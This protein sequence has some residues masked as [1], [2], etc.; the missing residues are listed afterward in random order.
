MEFATF[1]SFL[2]WRIHLLHVVVVI[3]LLDT[4]TRV[5]RVCYHHQTSTAIDPPAP[6]P[7]GLH[8]DW[9]IPFTALTEEW[10]RQVIA[11][12]SS[13]T[14]ASIKMCNKVL[15][16]SNIGHKWATLSMPHH[17]GICCAVYNYKM[18]YTAWRRIKL[19]FWSPAQD[20]PRGECGGFIVFSRKGSTK[21]MHTSKTSDDDK[22]PRR[23]CNMFPCSDSSAEKYGVGGRQRRRETCKE[24]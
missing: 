17:Q 23:C 11:Y 10:N 8:F 5:E 20:V 22:I 18:V 3:L 13:Q 14:R 15:N 6:T 24:K 9:K 7:P 1:F 4:T 21:R 2:H 12:Y 19:N 16:I